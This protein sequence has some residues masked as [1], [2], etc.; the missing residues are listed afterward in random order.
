MAFDLKTRNFLT[1]SPRN[2]N[3][4]NQEHPL[5]KDLTLPERLAALD[6]WYRK[7]GQGRWGCPLE[8]DYKNWMYYIP[9]GLIEKLHAQ[10]RDPQ[11][12]HLQEKPKKSKNKKKRD[13]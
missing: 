3:V 13:N 7:K 10:Y 5:Y 9:P 1:E 12:A 6:S 2:A 11:F 8:E 4:N